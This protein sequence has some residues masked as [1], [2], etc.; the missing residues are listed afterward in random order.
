MSTEEKSI[1]VLIVDDHQVVREGLRTFLELHA[2]VSVA[3]EAASGAEAVERARQLAPDV[4]L[5]DLVMPGMDGIEATR[6]IR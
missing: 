3:G 1:R 2:G 4:V 5:M 6:R